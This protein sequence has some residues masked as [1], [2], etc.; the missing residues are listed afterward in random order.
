M[1]DLIK[2]ASFKQFIN[3]LV[4]VGLLS[5]YSF[6]V[7]GQ[8]N[9]VGSSDIQNEGRSG[10]TLQPK[11]GTTPPS[12]ASKQS[13]TKQRV[14]IMVW[15]GLRPDSITKEETPNLF[16]LRRAGVNFSDNHA[17]YPSFTM[18]N[19]ASF[20]SGSFPR[21]S[22]FYG[23]TFWT[24]PP[25][26]SG[27]NAFGQVQSYKDPVFTE[28]YAI[29]KTLNNHYDDELIMVQSL[30]KTAH[31]AGLVTAS[32]G[33]S[34][35]AFLQDMDGGGYFLD[36]N[37]AYPLSFAKELQAAH[38]ALPANAVRGFKKGELTLEPK[39]ASPTKR[40]GYITFPIT[41]Y[42]ETIFSRDATD[43]TQGA[44]EESA[45]KYMM[46]VFTNYILPVK[47]LICP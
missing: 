14:I 44:P 32:I 5:F 2:R 18:M 10:A 3:G 47:N 31:K 15:D 23:N 6:A 12:D 22:G 29:L 40:D 25:G 21:K 1:N 42:G 30:F 4:Y 8:A 33:K 35:P 41:E 39:N 45:N 28:D 19:A 13:A 36:E 43:Q 34:G 9:A 11:I 17:T 27:T 26:P 24:P 38:I 7:L 16:E 46:S 37:A 20:A